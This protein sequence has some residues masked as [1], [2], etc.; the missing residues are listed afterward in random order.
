MKNQPGIISIA[1]EVLGYTS[2]T[3][4]PLPG[5]IS[6]QNNNSV[7]SSQAYSGGINSG[8][9]YGGYGGFTG[10]EKSLYGVSGSGRNVT[11]NHSLT[12]R[13]SRLTLHDS[14]EARAMVERIAN[15]G[16]ADGVKLEA[17]PIASMLGIT[18]EQARE[19]ADNVEQRFHLYC[20][21][22]DQSRDGN[23][24]LY[25]YQ[26]LYMFEQQRDNDNF[27]RLYYDDDPTLLSALQFQP[28]DSTQIKGNAFTFSAFPNGIVRDGIMR[29]EKG[30][31]VAY[32]VFVKAANGT[33]KEV[34][35]PAYSDVTRSRIN[36]LHGFMPE[37]AGQGR[38][39]SRLAHLIQD[40]Q[41]LTDFKVAYIQ[42]AINEASVFLKTQNKQQAPGNPFEG[43]DL[44]QGAGPGVR[45]STPDPEVSLS[46]V[47]TEFNI[48]NE[49][50]IFKPGM[51]I[52][53]AKQGDE[54]D[55]LDSKTPNA[56]YQQFVDSF[57]ASLCASMGS[58]IEV[59]LMKFN[60]NYSA[61]RA[62]LLLFWQELE[63]WRGEMATDLLHPLYKMWLSEEIFAGTITAP[64]WSDPRL[65]AAWLNNSWVGIPVPD[66][67]PQ[68]TAK[69]RRENISLG[70]TNGDR[71]S[72]MLNGTSIGSNIRKIVKEY[73]AAPPPPWIKNPGETSSS[74]GDA[75][76]YHDFLSDIE[77]MLD[78]KL[79]DMSGGN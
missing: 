66:I 10:G 23:L 9:Y 26:R 29:D 5:N 51:S 48:H 70:V 63:M 55:S 32:N 31:A 18:E 1:S 78:N 72:R 15:L 71:E 53:N 52:F 58:P 7:S 4:N 19:W 21:S 42:R 11:I 41:K 79:E 61:S 6:T 22:K 59:V 13:N 2:S 68:R 77:D 65:R 49:A 20:S 3:A 69:A 62:T 30:R 56:Q 39:F 14:S 47:P 25:Q 54:I 46:T 33:L 36:M 38:G 16:A 73:G 43:L 57:F 40:F 67:D 17:A 50:P 35:I 27:T 12:Q 44:S 60:Q 64:G 45:S 34:Q 37:Y 74:S 8:S 28:L 24:S 76:A 75:S